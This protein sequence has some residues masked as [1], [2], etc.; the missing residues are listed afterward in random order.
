MNEWRRRRGEIL[1]VIPARR[2]SRLPGAIGGVAVHPTPGGAQEDRPAGSSADVK[3]EGSGGGRRQ[4][5]GG[6]LAPL[7]RHR[8]GPMTAPDVQV[9]DVGAERFADP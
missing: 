7:A 8:Q 1:L 6:L 9:V 2:A 3:I 5:D 4:R